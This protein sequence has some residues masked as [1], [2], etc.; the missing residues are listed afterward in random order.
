LAIDSELLY[1]H[2]TISRTFIVDFTGCGAMLIMTLAQARKS[3]DGELIF[4]YYNLLRK[5]ADFLVQ[6]AKQSGN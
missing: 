6:S 1:N 2:L 5:W 4:K 3:G